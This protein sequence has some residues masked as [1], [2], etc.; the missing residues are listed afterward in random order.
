MATSD[1]N[2]PKHGASHFGGGA[3][4]ANS[5]AR[6]PRPVVGAPSAQRPGSVTS[7]S[8][9]TTGR[10]SSRT[11][12][13]TR[14][15]GSHNVRRAPRRPG[16]G[17]TVGIVAGVV[18]AVAVV[19]LLAFVVVPSFLAPSD[20]S[21]QAP[22]V[23][24][25]TQVTVTIP[26][27]SGATQVAQILYDNGV[28]SD[29][30]EFLGQARRTEAESQMKSGTYLFTAGAD[31]GSVIDLLVAGPNAGTTLT[32]PEGYTLAQI[33]QAV[34]QACGIPAADFTAQAT[35]ANYAADY[36]FLSGV[37]QESLEGF[38][39]PMTYTF[40]EDAVSADQVIRAMLDQM[41]TELSALD[42]SFPQSRGLSVAEVVNLAS[43]VEKEATPD[44]RA[45]VAGVMYNRLDTPGAP[46]YGLL[47]SDA[48]TAYSVGH[49]PSPEELNN[50]SDPYS[51]YVN[52]GLPPTPICSPSR[53]SL[54]AVC[55]PDQTMISDGYFY[56]YYWTNDA[57]ETECAFSR[58]LDEHNAAISNS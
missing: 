40:N 42:M 7:H 35:V 46:T 22:Q 14:R 5:S 37:S 15:A 4:R 6:A 45:Q 21:A 39:F 34:E 56:F 18:A 47:Q 19:A 30:G 29:Q 48:T 38:L 54:Q 43:I 11:A 16:G 41:G 1:G 51:T 32:I 25:G 53:D 9:L 20:D 57:G 8:A 13:A 26:D 36:D 17:R 55:S 31:L 50:A 3:P 44:T 58:T 24:A 52:Q 12:A 28:I 2:A 10:V 49:E 23:A 33:A 27:G